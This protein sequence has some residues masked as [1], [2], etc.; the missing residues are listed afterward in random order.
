MARYTDLKSALR[1]SLLCVA[2]GVLLLLTAP[3]A[4][5]DIDASSQRLHYLQTRQAPEA[6]A[7]RELHAQ[8]A[9]LRVYELAQLA[10]FG[11][12]AAMAD[13]D[14]RIATALV[15]ANKQLAIYASSQPT[16][17]ERSAFVE[18]RRRLEL[19]LRTHEQLAAAVHAGDIDAARLLSVRQALPQRR[20]LF[21]DLVVLTRL[22]GQ[23]DLGPA[24]DGRLAAI[25]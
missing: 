14:R 18:V 24:G 13:Y 25:D 21:A 10:E 19:Y 15:A 9:E 11:D 3:L 4:T 20:A 2:G 5:R 6:M 17:A 8:L 7:L 16:G 23:H 22:H 12:A 1:A